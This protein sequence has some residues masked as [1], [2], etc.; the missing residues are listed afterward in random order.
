MKLKVYLSG[1]MKSGWQQQFINISDSNLIEFFD[2]SKHGLTDSKEYTVWDL[3]YTKNCDI[4]FAY[5]EESNPTGFGLMLEIGYAKALG[6]TII[7][8]DEKS[9]K[10]ENFARSFKIVRESATIVFE[11]LDEGIEF[12]KSF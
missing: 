8:V 6:K 12:L 7:L 9:K 4:L 11:T 1:G 10:D 5:M 3:F 2:P